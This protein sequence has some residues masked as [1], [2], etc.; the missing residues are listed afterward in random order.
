IAFEIL[1][2]GIPPQDPRWAGLH[3]NYV[4]LFDFYVALVSGAGR[5][6]PFVVMAIFNVVNSAVCAGLVAIAARALWRSESAAFGAGAL[7]ITGLNA[8]AWLLYP[9]RAIYGLLG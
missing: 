3:L 4:W 8:G 5:V 2:R 1:E 7:A 6:D 9:M